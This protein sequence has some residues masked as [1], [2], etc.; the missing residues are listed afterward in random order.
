MGVPD[1][2][3][4]SLPYSIQ[5][6]EIGVLNLSMTCNLQEVVFGYVSEVDREDVFLSGIGGTPHEAF[7]ELYD[8]YR[9]FAGEQNIKSQ[10]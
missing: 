9:Q 3:V 10:N 4:Y 7:K 8:A 6:P 5:S 1:G 2:S